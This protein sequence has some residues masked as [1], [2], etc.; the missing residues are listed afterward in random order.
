L[1]P[2]SRS[3]H[4]PHTRWDTGFNNFYPLLWKALQQLEARQGVKAFCVRGR[5][6]GPQILRLAFIMGDKDNVRRAGQV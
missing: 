2:K 4:N 5:I 3:E 6:T 1:D